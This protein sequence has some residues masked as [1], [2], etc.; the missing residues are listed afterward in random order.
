M[1]KALEEDGPDWARNVV[2]EHR[3]GVGRLFE[4]MSARAR[5]RLTKTLLPS[6]ASS[7]D[8]AWKAME[9]RPFQR[10]EFRKPFRCPRS[11]ADLAELRGSWLLRTAMTLGEYDRDI[12]WVATWAAH[13]ADWE[14]ATEI[15][16]L[17][18][19]A[20]DRG[21]NESDEVLEILKASASGD[22]DVAQMGRHVTQA[23]MASSREDAW[24]F[25]EKLLLA[26]QRQEGLRQAILEA[27]DESHPEAFR[28]MLRLI[29]EE[30]LGRF[31]SVVRAFDTWFG[32]MWDGSSRLALNEVLEKVLLFFDEPERRSAAIDGVEAEPAYL[33]LWTLAFEDVESAIPPA[34]RM[35]ADSS[36]EKRFVATHLL[37]QMNW[38][39]TCRE[40]ARMLQDD[41]LR[42]AA[43]ALMCFQENVSQWIDSPSLFGDLERLL[44]RLDKRSTKLESLVWPWWNIK[45][46]RSAVAQAMSANS[47]GVPAARMLPYLKDLDPY[48]REAHVRR[49]AGLPDRWSQQTKPK[50]L[51]G[52]VYDA[53]L[54]LLGDPSPDVR[55]A[56]FQAMASTPL[57]PGETDRL[58]G[59]LNRKAGDLRN[60]CIDRL[61]SL[62]DAAML[63]AAGRL[64]ADRDA[65]RRLAG[66]ELLREAV[67]AERSAVAAR[68][69]AQEHCPDRASVGDAERSHLDAILGTTEA[70][71]ERDDALGLVDPA[72]L[73]TW[74]E[75]EPRTVGLESGAASRC[76]DSLA[77]RILEHQDFEFD[78]GSGDR[79]LL[80]DAGLRVV[81]PRSPELAAENEEK[82]PL[83]EQWRSWAGNRGE[84]LRDADGLELVRAWFAR[85]SGPGWRGKH[86]RQLLKAGRWSSGAWLLNSLLEWCLYWEPPDRP[87]DL[88]LDGLESSLAE[89][90]ERDFRDMDESRGPRVRVRGKKE[91][92]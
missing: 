58:V 44:A 29:L 78:C 34:V 40:L 21:G 49:L 71:A 30:N 11:A 82:L 84:A 66:L 51:A 83:A 76:I 89:L 26:A 35:L 60:R 45:L 16:W 19:G 10:G 22:H 88:L 46:E 20:L 77:Q 50:R 25:N 33:A 53:V 62:A 75:P 7:V 72:R 74:N 70:L 2:E 42:V 41:D 55:R 92:P 8:A 90:T 63:D 87:F 37:A 65:M 81:E 80:I 54:E 4:G 12:T 17:L 15:G 9:R 43:R 47:E 61:R 32:F 31:S 86:A 36:V 5:L 69:L 57:K 14:V 48:R 3:G 23:L 64:L 27:V 79:M 39:P 1:V 85:Q 91:K 13:L 67:E 52:S 56:A 18:A 6:L 59:L 38:G 68:K 24:E 28:R 73:P